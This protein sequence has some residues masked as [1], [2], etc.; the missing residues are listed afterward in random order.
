MC[1]YLKSFFSILIFDDYG[2]QLMKI[3][4]QECQNIRITWETSMFRGRKVKILDVWVTGSW[5]ELE[6]RSWEGLMT[7]QL[8]RWYTLTGGGGGRPQRVTAKGA[9]CSPSAVSKQSHRKLPGFF[10]ICKPQSSRL[11]H[12][13][14]LKYFTNIEQMEVSFFNGI[15]GKDILFFLDIPF[16]K[17]KKQKPKMEP[18]SHVLVGLCLSAA[19]LCAVWQ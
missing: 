10:T 19:P 8:C 1:L 9:A 3:K 7:W 2:P 12:K 5:V 13:K 11:K 16:L 4:S 17:K 18:Q 15:T 6:S 14:G